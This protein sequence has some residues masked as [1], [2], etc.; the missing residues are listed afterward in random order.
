M[1][2]DEVAENILMNCGDQKKTK[3]D[4]PSQLSCG[5]HDLSNSNPYRTVIV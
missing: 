1:A 4:L 3:S 5:D 2:D